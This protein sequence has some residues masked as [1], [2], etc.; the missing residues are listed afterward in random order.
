MAGKKHPVQC[1][2]FEEYREMF[3]G[4]K[5]DKLYDNFVLAPMTNSLILSV[6]RCG[7]PNLL[8]RPPFTIKHFKLGLPTPK[9][10]NACPNQD[11]DHGDVVQNA[12]N[13][14]P[15][16]HHR[17]EDT[18]AANDD[19]PMMDVRDEPVV[20][21]ISKNHNKPGSCPPADQMDQNMAEV[22]NG[23]YHLQ[24]KS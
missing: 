4:P 15:H 18:C 13:V 12:A 23:G 21:A 10:K 3:F 20:E 6:N 8:E 16:R 24:D 22:N 17:D 11:T 5:Q 2:R 14:E 9:D 1:N 7:P 19:V